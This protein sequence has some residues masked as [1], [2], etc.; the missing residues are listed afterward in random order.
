MERKLVIWVT[1]II[2]VLFAVI[3]AQ[4]F[5]QQPSTPSGTEAGSSSAAPA[6]REGFLGPVWEAYQKVRQD[7]YRSDQVKA[8]EMQESAIQGMIEALGDPYSR[9]NSREE[10]ER[11]SEGLEGEYEGIGAWIGKRGGELTIISP[12]K[13]GPAKGAGVRAG[14]AILEIDGEDASELSINEAAQ[15]LRGP[16]G[17]KVTVKVRHT[18]G[19][20]ETIGIVRERIKVPSVESKRIE[21]SIAYISV[22]RFGSSTPRE[23]RDAL[24]K[25]RQGAESVEGLV[26]D[27]RGNGGGY[28]QAA[29]Q[30]ASTFVD[31]GNPLLLEGRG[32]RRDVHRSGGNGIPNW[33]IAVLVDEG[34]ASGAEIVAGA[35]RDNRMGVLIGRNTFGKGVIQSTFRMPEGAVLFL[36]TAEYFTPDGH[37]VHEAG[38]TPREPFTVK[39]WYPVLLDVRKEIHA[40]ETALPKFADASRAVLQGFGQELNEVEQHALEDQ[41]EEAL[42]ALKQLEGRLQ[43]DPEALLREAG[44]SAEDS[45]AVLIAP[46]LQEL[47]K[48]IDPL[49]AQ[50]RTRIEDNAIAAALEWLKSAELQGARCPCEFIEKMPSTN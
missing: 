4:G 46:L 50:L 3:L 39:D 7:F 8:D 47:G 49:M 14:D 10:F 9:Y 16:K 6:D 40:L 44:A 13:G 12:I 45:E 1:A 19:T 34:T 30:V 22:N 21:P 11:F 38:L 27:L 2:V 20:L 35:I 41:Y 25:L 36:T 15:K 24:R 29:E 33:P 18:D 32:D 48:A 17:T 37:Q 5:L 28:L 43:V 42:G 31:E 26:L 23:L